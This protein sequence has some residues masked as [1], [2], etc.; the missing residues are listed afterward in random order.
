MGIDS[1]VCFHKWPFLSLSNREGMC[2]IGSVEPLNGINKDVCGAKLREPTTVSVY[3]V[4]C[5]CLCHLL[6]T[7][8]ITACV[9]MEALARL[10][11]P[12][13]PPSPLPPTSYPPP[14]TCG[15]ICDISRCEKVAQNP[16]V[17]TSYS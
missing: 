4:D 10:R 15:A 11:L 1:Q 16:A 3:P 12:T 5:D 9:L 7:Q 8:Y 17:L 2:T 13:H 6:D 14:Y